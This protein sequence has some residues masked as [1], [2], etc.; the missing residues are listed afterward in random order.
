MG[1]LPKIDLPTYD[2][3]LPSSGM[4]I[5][6][7]PFLVKEEKLLLMAA[8]SN[9]DAE[10]IRAVQQIV[11]NCILTEGIDVTKL[12]FFDVDY[13]FIALRAKSVGESIDIK[14]ICN[15]LVDGTACKTSFPAKIDIANVAVEKTEIKNPISMGKIL[16]KMRYPSYA[17]MKTIMDSDAILN[18]NIQIAVSSIEQIIDGDKVT[19]LKDVTREELVEFV[20]NLTKDQFTKLEE[21]ITNFP[22]FFV[23]AKATCPKCNFSH[24]LE[25][26]DFASFFE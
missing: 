8:E 13:L 4:E 7:R 16:V 5:T 11:S 20:E 22:T 17:A 24:E 6:I 15:N 21:W 14:Y 10:I 26:R 18:K 1:I 23:Q 19:T 12:P 25:Y 9:D 3:K 2:V